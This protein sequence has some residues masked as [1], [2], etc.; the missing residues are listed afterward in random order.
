MR[1]V[2]EHNGQPKLNSIKIDLD[3]SHPELVVEA[4]YPGGVEGADLFVEA[5]DGLYV[6]LPDRETLGDGKRMRF[7]IDLT[8]GEDAKFLRGKEL[9]LTLVGAHGQSETRWRVPSN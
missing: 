4:E 9:Q 6:A 8:K 5:P 7:R 1:M 3:G 2:P